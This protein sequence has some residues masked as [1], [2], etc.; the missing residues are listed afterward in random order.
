M[1]FDTAHIMYSGRKHSMLWLS[2]FGYMIIGVT[3]IITGI[4]GHPDP[5]FDWLG[6]YIGAL[7]EPEYLGWLWVLAGFIQTLPIVFPKTRNSKFDRPMAFGFGAAI[8]APS[9]WAAIYMLSG[10]H[11]YIYGP[12][13]GVVFL[14]MAAIAW[15]ISGWDEPS[16]TAHVSRIVEHI[17]EETDA[18]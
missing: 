7:S 16:A 6:L 15:E 11:G 17:K 8:L 4:Y 1:S 3:W 10:A 2:G 12:R 9:V 13:H 14:I 18:S 5:A